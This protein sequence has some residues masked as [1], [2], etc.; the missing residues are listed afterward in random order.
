M[1]KKNDGITL[2]YNTKDYHDLNFI[3][4]NVNCPSGAQES[5]VSKTKRDNEIFGRSKTRLLLVSP[6]VSQVNI[7]ACGICTTKDGAV[8]P[9]LSY[10][11]L[12]RFV[13]SILKVVLVCFFFY[14]Q[15]LDF[16]NVLTIRKR[17]RLVNRL[18]SKDVSL[19]CFFFRKP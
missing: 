16:K 15:L 2:D 10:R 14:L 3:E 1:K 5:L 17:D 9:Q 13:L 11:R 19:I 4:R 7:S 6:R 18:F 12:D 8:I